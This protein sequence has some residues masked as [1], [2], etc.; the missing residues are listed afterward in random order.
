M[1]FLVNMGIFRCHVSLPK[2]TLL[3]LRA[4]APANWWLED[5]SFPFGARAHLQV[6]LLLVLTSGPGVIFQV[7][8]LFFF[9][10]GRVHSPKLTAIP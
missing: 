5:D 3:K 4:K 1:Y 2:G 7:K 10:F 6:L 9:N 8:Q